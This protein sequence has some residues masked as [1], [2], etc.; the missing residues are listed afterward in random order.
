MGSY[1]LD[2]LANGVGY[3]MVLVIVGF[4]SRGSS[5]QSTAARVSSSSAKLVCGR[6][7]GFYEN[8]GLFIM[9][10]IEADTFGCFDMGQRWRH[11]ELVEEEVESGGV[12]SKAEIV[13]AMENLLSIFVRSSLWTI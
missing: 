7:G 1:I 4:F 11:K 12:G 5:V 8:N 6:N 9:P 10:S 2:G 3:G 13:G